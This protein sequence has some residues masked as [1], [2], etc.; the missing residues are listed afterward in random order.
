MRLMFDILH[1]AINN[2][3]VSKRWWGVLQSFLLKDPPG[4]KVHRFRNIT[5]VEADLTFI[6]K[7]VWTKKLGNR[8][9]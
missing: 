1:V 9:K 5:I 7:N 6:M 8:L 4:S 2:W 3:I